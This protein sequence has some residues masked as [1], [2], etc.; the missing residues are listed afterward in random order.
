MISLN[1]LVGLC[2]HRSGTAAFR[3]DKNSETTTMTSLSTGEKLCTISSRDVRLNM[4]EE[5]C[6]F[7]RS[8]GSLAL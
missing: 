3:N 4:F 5:S 7:A 8:G 6:Q 1:F 2:D